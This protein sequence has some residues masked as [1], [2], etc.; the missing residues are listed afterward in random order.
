VSKVSLALQL[1]H[2]LAERAIERTRTKLKLLDYFVLG[3][4]AYRLRFRGPASRAVTERFFQLIRQVMSL[5]EESTAPFEGAIE[6]DET[7]FGGYRKGKRGWGAAGKVIVL[8]I[9][10]RSGQS[11]SDHG[12]FAQDH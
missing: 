4:P 8:G 5:A 7:M 2:C 1:S 12:T 3:V 9:L 11:V 6:C 10:Q